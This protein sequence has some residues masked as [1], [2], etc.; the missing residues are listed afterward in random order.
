MF[1]LQE[2]FIPTLTFPKLCSWTA[3]KFLCIVQIKKIRLEPFVTVVILSTW[4]SKFMN[5]NL[6]LTESTNSPSVLTI[7]TFFQLEKRESLFA[8]NSK[9]RSPKIKLKFQICPK[10]SCILNISLSDKRSFWKSLKHKILMQNKREIN[11]WENPK[12]S[13]IDYLM[14]GTLK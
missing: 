13:M 1:R 4:A 9:I 3:K 14:N 11:F 5:S 10:N 2:K 6:T 8:T 12:Q 7:I